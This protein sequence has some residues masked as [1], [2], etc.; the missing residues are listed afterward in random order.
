MKRFWIG[1][2]VVYVL[3]LAGYAATNEVVVTAS[4]TTRRVE[5]IAASVDV[6]ERDTVAMESAISVD[7]LFRSVGGVD[8]Q[9]SGLPGAAV[10]LNMRGLTPGYQSKRV[11]VLMNGRRINEQYQGNAELA[12]LPADGIARIEVLRGPASALYGSGAMGGVIQVVSLRGCDMVG[13]GD[14]A[15]VSTLRLAAGSHDTQH[16]RCGQGGVWRAVDYFVSGSYVSTG[17][18]LQNRD[19]TDRDWEA[20]RLGG[21][22]G[23]TGD[24]AELRVFSGFY[25]GKGRDDNSLRTV[26]KNYQ[27]VDWTWEWNRRREAQLLVRA[28]RNADEDTYEWVYPGTGFYDQNTLGAELQQSLWVGDRHLATAGVE[29]REES[30]DIDEV[31]GPID[32]STSV[33]AGYV[34]DEVILNEAVEASAGIRYDNTGGYGDTWSPR[35]GVVWHLCNRL[36]FYGAVNVAHR[37]PGLADR[38]V[39]QEFNGMLFVGNPD[40][41]PEMLTAYE[42]G[43]RVR[44]TR[45]LRLRLALFRNDMDDTFDFTRD[46]DGVFRIRNVTASRTQG[47]EA[48]LRVGLTARTSFFGNW[49]YTEGVYEAAAGDPRIIDRR[50]AY[51]APNKGAIGLSIE[52]LGRT[53][54]TLLCRYVGARYGDALN[55]AA[56]RMDA[57][58]VADWRGRLHATEQL[59]LTVNLNNI[60]DTSYEEFPGVKQPGAFLMVGVE[61]RF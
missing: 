51:L 34:Q 12:L 43:A 54:H 38:F 39:Q 5:D 32:E 36:D 37:A 50:L 9:G 44:P 46:P 59:D 42:V 7:E 33:V 6:L 22:M 20:W 56:N 55:T 52:R 25:R 8:L 17:G 35:V 3:V 14:G 19:G 26:A 28:W 61:G 58:V 27:Q 49:S 48:A 47:V 18:Y 30:V 31:S 29:L 57:Y 11:L 40:L 15:H 16:V 2:F 10:K 53:S 45:R 21:N 1:W 23:W 41:E 13:T 24:R 60:F 4:R